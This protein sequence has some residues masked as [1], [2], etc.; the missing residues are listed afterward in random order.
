MARVIDL[1][2]AR[3]R[4][5][6][7]SGTPTPERAGQVGVAL[8]GLGEAVVQL[9]E[10]MVV[11]RA[12]EEA[13]LGT[14]AFKVRL[15]ELM[16]KYRADPD[17]ATARERFAQDVMAAAEA[18]K[19]A[20]THPRSRRLFDVQVPGYVATA[21]AEFIRMSAARQVE[22]LIASLSAL[23][24]NTLIELPSLAGEARQQRI[25]DVMSRIRL[26]AP[27]IGPARAQELARNFEVSAAQ[28]VIFDWARR[29]GPGAAYQQLATTGPADPEIRGLWSRLTPM[30]QEALRNRVLAEHREQRQVAAANMA[31][32]EQAARMAARAAIPDFLD[33]F[34]RSQ[35]A[36]EPEERAQARAVAEQ[37]LRE[38][39]RL[40]PTVYDRYHGLMYGPQHG[41][42][43]DPSTVF[44]IETMI[45]T[46][47]ALTYPR[48]DEAGR[49]I[50]GQSWTIP[51][52]VYDHM[53][54]GRI[55]ISTARDLLRAYDARLGEELSRLREE[56]RAHFAAPPLDVP[57][58]QLSETKKAAQALA[59]KVWADFLAARRAN[60]TLDPG[61]WWE[62]YRRRLPPTGV[63][64][65][66]AASMSAARDVMRKANI[67]FEYEQVRRLHNALQAQR[68]SIVAHSSSAQARQRARNSGAPLPPP[69]VL[70]PGISAQD[71]RLLIQYLPHIASL[72]EDQFQFLAELNMGN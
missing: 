12:Q 56:V 17:Q 37:L 23:I 7:F 40:D 72:S 27:Q 33:A 21:T 49:A 50:P 16:Q 57:S 64:L 35:T 24:D 68:D 52:M 3:G 41:A 4:L 69:P 6:F 60:P 66:A 44:A 51:E 15:A 65:D 45:R 71:A 67:P 46:D 36:E 1:Y 70:P 32:A 29:I 58:S 8:A 31:I 13:N 5:P 59:A 63:V 53:M 26:A 30:Q 22:N 9:G 61:R 25:A 48:E 55:T 39:L 11:A 28:S 18:T 14:A 47:P 10:Q 20:M 43:D 54:R 62:D 42:R 38:R 2:Q 19:S 34:H